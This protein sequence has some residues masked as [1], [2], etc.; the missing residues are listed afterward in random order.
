MLIQWTFNFAT[1][2][3][4]LYCIVSI[5]LEP[6]HVWLFWSPDTQD[7]EGKNKTQNM[8]RHTKHE[9]YMI[10][11]HLTTNSFPVDIIT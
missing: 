6:F 9:S 4:V 5:T 8:K 3:S 2:I 1:K 7:T 10:K 11:N